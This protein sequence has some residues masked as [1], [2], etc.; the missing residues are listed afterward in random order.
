M[1]RVPIFK[2]CPDIFPLNLGHVESFT[3]GS[4]VNYGS[5]SNY[6]QVGIIMAE[7]YLKT[8]IS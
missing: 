1:P 3:P 4:P 5:S 8:P 6:P 7:E 2:R